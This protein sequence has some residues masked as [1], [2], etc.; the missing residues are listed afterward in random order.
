MTRKA[1]DLKVETYPYLAND[2]IRH[3]RYGVPFRL[4]CT[5]TIPPPISL[6]ACTFFRRCL[7]VACRRRTKSRTELRRINF[8]VFS[9]SKPSLV[10]CTI[11]PFSVLIS[12]LGNGKLDI[13]IGH[14]IRLREKTNLFGS[15]ETTLI[16]NH[17]DSFSS[18]FF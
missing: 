4:A 18:A 8:S 2:T 12:Y 7:Q 11:F 9:K 5:P 14:R 10:Q 17:L 1:K 15:I 16:P 3:P 6:T 13:E